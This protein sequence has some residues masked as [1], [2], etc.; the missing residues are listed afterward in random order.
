MDK[1][2]ISASRSASNSVSKKDLESL[3]LQK[4][5]DKR[6]EKELARKTAQKN[7]SQTK[8]SSQRVLQGRATTQN[9]T[10]A[11]SRTTAQNKTVAQSKA[12]HKVRHCTRQDNAQSKVATSNK[13]GGQN[14][15][16]KVKLL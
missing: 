3:N 16:R 1:K 12:M 10:V 9:K 6:N 2:R 11:Q 15:L 4:E 14:Q 13:V 7:K 8:Q 5:I